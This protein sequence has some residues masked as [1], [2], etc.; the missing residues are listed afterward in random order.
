MKSIGYIMLLLLLVFYLYA[1][2]GIM[3][4]RDNDPWHFGDLFTALL[5]LFRAST[6]EDWTDIMYINLYGCGNDEYDSGIYTLNE[7]LAN[8]G[9]AYCPP[10]HETGKAALSVIYFVTFTVISALVML[11]LFIGK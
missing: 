3:A 5:T 2:A 10:G 7:T 9:T 11:S 4:F 6:L 1:I 8:R